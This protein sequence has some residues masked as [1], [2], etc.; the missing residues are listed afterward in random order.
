MER[1][2]SQ[3]LSL[4]APEQNKKVKGWGHRS[5]NN[6]NRISGY[7]GTIVGRTSG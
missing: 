6:W 2:L 3:G 4:P 1:C 7:I 5:F